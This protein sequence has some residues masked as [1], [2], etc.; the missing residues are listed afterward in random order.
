MLGGPLDVL[1]GLRRLLFWQVPISPL[2][3]PYI[4]PISPL[5]LPHISPSADTDEELE[6]E[7]SSVVIR[8]AQHR[9]L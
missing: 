7:V 8:V 9:G 1:R 4:S 2:Y 5:D 6:L 3:L